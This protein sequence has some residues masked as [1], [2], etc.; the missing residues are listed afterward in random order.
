MGAWCT[1]CRSC[2]AMSGVLCE[3]CR[4]MAALGVLVQSVDPTDVL[5]LDAIAFLLIERAM[6]R[7][8][9]NKEMFEEQ[10]GAQRDARSAYDE[11]LA[12]GRRD[13]SDW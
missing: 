1:H 9:H 8:R 7:H 4:W 12:D 13:H 3:R 10:R 2:W 11:G 6:T 5:E